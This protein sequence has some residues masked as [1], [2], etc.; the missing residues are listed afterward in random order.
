MA[1]WKPLCRLADLPEGAPVAKK[2][3][4]KEFLAVRRGGR[5]FVCA[6]K[7]PHY[8][9]PLSNGVT[10]GNAII[11]P[12]HYARFDL[13]SGRVDSAPALDDL[14]TYEV[15]V[16]GE[17]ILVGPSRPAPFEL[18]P[19]ALTEQRTFVIVG[20]GAA[21]EAAVEALVRQGFGGR[22]VLVTAEE[23]L[24]YN[25]TDL[26]KGFLTGEVQRDWLQLRGADFYS[27]LGVEVMAGTQAEGLDPAR[28]TLR[29]DGGR[30][31]RYDRLL[32]ATGAGARSLEVPGADLAGCFTLRGRDDAER[33]I[34][35]LADAGRAVIVG[36][37]YIGL[38]VASALRAKG[39]E[40]DVV[41]PEE[42]PL[43]PLLGR[44]FGQRIRALH[45]TKGTRF[46][47]GRTVS[48]VR[49]E[50]R[51]KEVVLSDG[52]RLAADLVIVGIGAE[53][54]VGWLS[55]SGLAE[56]GAVP[57]DGTLR[58]RDPDVFAAGDLALVPEPRLGRS[59]RFEHWISAQKQGRHAALAMLGRAEPYREV[60]FFWSIQ[61]DTSIKYAGAAGAPYDRVVYRG[62]PA[63][64]S[65]LAAYFAAGSLI[66]AATFAMS[67]NLIAIER[68]MREGRSVT[69]DQ[70]ADER[71]SLLAL[72][73]LTSGEG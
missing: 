25:R 28:R 43:A 3:G 49:G 61:C 67:W 35:A 10:S 1:E 66:G 60:P 56:A 33:I 6:N 37:G 19:R 30:E 7:C 55:G 24:P 27:T 39:L 26:S 54:R 22:I 72:A 64:D 40:V 70:V 58:A 29:L 17:E 38:E 57:V 8:G 50:D 63:G 36:A 45:E 47:M 52:S 59:L 42:L 46:H 18:K 51:V 73:G 41:A 71:T 2:I 15:K 44:E 31:L 34:A 20:G 32:V 11:C 68:L 69:P 23:H 12:S 53:P 9:D 48:E 13:A 4:K 16:E 21:G 5:V 14:A 65:F 62:S